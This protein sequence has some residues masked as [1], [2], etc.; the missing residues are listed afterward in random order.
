MIELETS[1]QGVVNIVEIYHFD[2]IWMHRAWFSEEIVDENQQICQLFGLKSCSTTL[3][4]R[5]WSKWSISNTL[6]TSQGGS[7]DLD[8]RDMCSLIESFLGK[9][10]YFWRKIN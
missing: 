8:P 4:I 1:N 3:Y 5:I 9:K 10:D 6:T 2:R 7:Q